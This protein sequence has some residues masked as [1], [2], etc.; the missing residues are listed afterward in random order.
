M[1]TSLIFLSKRDNASGI[2]EDKTT[3]CS[4]VRITGECVK[5]LVHYIAVEKRL[6]ARKVHPRPKARPRHSQ[7]HNNNSFFSFF[8]ILW[9]SSSSPERDVPATPERAPVIVLSILFPGK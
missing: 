6:T 4:R 7:T 2:E 1:I 9:D 3:D 5:P 8:S